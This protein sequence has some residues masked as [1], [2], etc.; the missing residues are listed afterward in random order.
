MVTGLKFGLIIGKNTKL[1]KNKCVNLQLE[2]GKLLVV[3]A[4]LQF[5]ELTGEFLKKI[6][7]G[8]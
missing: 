1:I 5:N 2:T 3:V 6:K 7:R 8:I 4:L